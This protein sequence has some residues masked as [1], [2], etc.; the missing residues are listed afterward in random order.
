VSGYYGGPSY[1]ISGEICWDRAVAVCLHRRS[2]LNPTLE[3]ANSA[4]SPRYD[5]IPARIHCEHDFCFKTGANQL[6]LGAWT[7][8]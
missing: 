7:G 8:R 3:N 4:A 5:G 1:S 6:F 2:F